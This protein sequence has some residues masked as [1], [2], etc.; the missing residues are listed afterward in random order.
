VYSCVSIELLISNNLS[1]F[2]LLD[3]NGIKQLAMLAMFSVLLVMRAMPSKRK[4]IRNQNKNQKSKHANYFELK[5]PSSLITRIEQDHCL[6][7]SGNIIMFFQALGI[8]VDLW[9]NKLEPL[10]S[11]F[12]LLIE[13][14]IFKISALS[15]HLQTN[16]WHWHCGPKWTHNYTCG[17]MNQQVTEICVNKTSELEQATP[18]Q[19]LKHSWNTA[20]STTGGLLLKTQ[21]K[22]LSQK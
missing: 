5:W 6:E 21:L 11:S 10:L 9:L 19:L 13:M 14:K 3:R 16:C 15:L 20:Q 2:L 12:K 7:N 1:S 18:S 17:C 22:T 4:K 8:Y